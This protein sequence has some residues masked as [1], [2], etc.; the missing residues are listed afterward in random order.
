MRT[1][2]S[3]A[4]V[5]KTLRNQAQVPTPLELALPINLEEGD[6]FMAV[7]FVSWRMQKRA[8][9]SMAR[10]HHWGSK[11]RQTEFANVEEWKM[12]VLLRVWT[13]VP[14]LDFVL[15]NLETVKVLDASDFGYGLCHRARRTKLLYLL[16]FAERT[17]RRLRLWFLG[18]GDIEDFLSVLVDIHFRVSVRIPFLLIWSFLLFLLL[19]ML[20]ALRRARCRRWRSSKVWGME[21]H[22]RCW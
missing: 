21:R 5:Q 13:E 18:N 3:H 19:G 14:R 7:Y 10:N 15:A 6:V 17:S 8:A 1:I 22:C 16:L 2:V 20:L 9:H 12:G 11:V 4:L